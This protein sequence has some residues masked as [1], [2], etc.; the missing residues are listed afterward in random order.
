MN[1][2]D[3]LMAIVL[4]L[5]SRRQCTADTLAEVFEV[6][7]RTIYRDVQ[8]LLEA[9]VPIISLPGFGY[10]I[11]DGYFLPP[12]NF[13]PDEALMLLLGAD[14]MKQNFDAGY[15]HAAE[16]AFQKISAVLPSHQRETVEYLK[17]NIEFFTV[18]GRT[19]QEFEK[20]HSLRRAI[21]DCQR[22][23]I[24]YTK[25][26]GKNNQP[27]T[28]LRDVDPYRLAW[29]NDGWFLM[30]YCHLRSELRVFRLSRMNGVRVLAQQFERP[31]HLTQSWENPSQNRQIEVRVLFKIEA[32]RW[33]QEH[34]SFF[35][36]EQK[37][38]MDGLLVTL[39][40]HNYDEIL[41]WLLGWG[42]KVQVLE[43]VDLQERLVQAAQG[44]LETYQ[45]KILDY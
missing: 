20:L 18:V 39:A 30:G 5:Q 23:Q 10:S 19:S 34:P 16:Q 13:S 14:F 24:D 38:V 4:E 36:I 9:G 40:V 27:E 31:L 26:F 8:A 1:R 29:L 25:R 22:V 28:S 15:R 45:A 35:I 43:P 17:D 6:S 11:M 21:L 7:K 12:L 32:K 44:I 33:M 41:H 2:T 37:E 42:D 3:R